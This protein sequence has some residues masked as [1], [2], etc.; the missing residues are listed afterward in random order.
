MIHFECTGCNDI[1][2]PGNS[3]RLRSF[4]ALLAFRTR[5]A[6]P[7][8][9]QPGRLGTESR[10]SKHL[11]DLPALVIELHVVR[12]NGSQVQKF[13]FSLRKIGQFCR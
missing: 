2:R 6:R 4:F 11:L 9:R 12:F 1:L 7:L 13:K 10:R 5:P 8:G 3:R